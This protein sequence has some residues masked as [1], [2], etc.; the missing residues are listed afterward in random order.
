MWREIFIITNQINYQPFYNMSRA[1]YREW[2]FCELDFATY[3]NS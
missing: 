2:L 3:L 1:V